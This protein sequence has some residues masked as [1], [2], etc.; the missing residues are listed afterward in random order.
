MIAI[1]ENAWKQIQNHGILENGHVSHVRP[2][3]ALKSFAYKYLDFGIKQF[4]SD[5]KSNKNVTKT[6]GCILKPGQCI[7]LVN[8]DDYNNSLENLFDNISKFQLCEIFQ[9]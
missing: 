4:M 5:S 9:L 8:K 6:D 3:T 2:K 7:V 1:V